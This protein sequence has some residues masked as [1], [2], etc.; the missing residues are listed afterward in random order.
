MKILFVNNTKNLKNIGCQM[1][2]QGLEIL[3]QGHEVENFFAES[4]FKINQRLNTSR[5]FRVLTAPINKFSRRY[6]SMVKEYILAN[7]KNLVKSIDE[8]DLILING[9]GS[10]HHNRVTGIVLLVIASIAKDRGKTVH[11]VNSTLQLLSPVQIREI[12]R[13]DRI[14]V[15]EIYSK[16]FLL[17]HGVESIL[18]ADAAWV[19]LENRFPLLKLSG[20]SGDF[21]KRVLVTL[22]TTPNYEG[23]N[24]VLLRNNIDKSKLD[25]LRIDDID[26]N[27]IDKLEGDC[28]FGKILSGEDVLR[29]PKILLENYSVVITGRH[30]IAILSYFLGIKVVPLFANTYKI[31]ST[32]FSIIGES[33]RDAVVLNDNEIQK[34]IALAGKNINL[35]SSH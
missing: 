18:G 29:D 9:E 4:V 20:K 23:L 3:L 12:K 17:G 34:T 27:H 24:E 33:S 30:H 6:F 14:V 15:R 28:K 11:L 5:S 26:I 35:I 21:D 25:Y 13:L 7:K 10:I 19:F 1:T 22:G 8:N 31:E 16:H 2:S 32:I